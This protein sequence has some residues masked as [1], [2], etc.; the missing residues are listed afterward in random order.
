MVGKKTDNKEVMRDFGL[1]QS[2]QYLAISITL[3]VLLL[4]L[5]L[6]KRSDLFMEIPKKVIVSVQ[7][8]VIA[9]FAIFSAF[10]WRCPSCK[11]YLGADIGRRVCKRC[12]IRLR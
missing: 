12:G 1:R 11:K 2:R 9:A 3:V 5:F 4:I 7:I 10:N 6:Y 8:G